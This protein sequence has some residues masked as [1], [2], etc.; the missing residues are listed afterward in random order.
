LKLSDVQLKEARLSGIFEECQKVE[1]AKTEIAKSLLDQAEIEL[2]RY[3]FC[4]ENQ[5]HLFAAFQPLTLTLDAPIDLLVRR[6]SP[7][8]LYFSAF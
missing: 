7:R 6:L 4:F 3:F 8:T 2:Q 1:R 5:D